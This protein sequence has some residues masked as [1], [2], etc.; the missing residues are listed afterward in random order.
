V[1]EGGAE[2]QAAAWLCVAFVGIGALQKLFDR[3]RIGETK[4]TYI[5]I[6]CSALA[7]FG[8]LAFEYNVATATAVLA[9]DDCR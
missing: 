6:D 5:S 3:S 9:T 1:G 7:A 2:V 8:S 4:E